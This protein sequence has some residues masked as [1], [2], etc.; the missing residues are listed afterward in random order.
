MWHSFTPT[1]LISHD[2]IL[3]RKIWKARHARGR[4]GEAIHSKPG[5]WQNCEGQ[6]IATGS[7][8][9]SGWKGHCTVRGFQAFSIWQALRH[10]TLLV[11]LLL[12]VCLLG[13]TVWISWAF[14]LDILTQLVH[15]DWLYTCIVQPYNSYL[16]NRC[17]DWIGEKGICDSIYR[18]WSGIWCKSLF[19]L[20]IIVFG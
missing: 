14:C 16:Q 19:F 1:L 18:R 6:I 9:S 5:R 20:C 12:A 17:L 15:P 11:S 4:D 8:Q 2:V 7:V 10:D 3:F 13:T